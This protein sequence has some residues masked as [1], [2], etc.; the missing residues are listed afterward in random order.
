LIF[1]A[2][3]S[4]IASQED[5]YFMKQHNIGNACGTIAVIH[6]I[7]N[8]FDIIEFGIYLFVC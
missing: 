2:S 6:S 1:D 7:A 8:N 4:S 3:P 5:I